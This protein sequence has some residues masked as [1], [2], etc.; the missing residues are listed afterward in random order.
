MVT[1]SHTILSLMLMMRTSL[2]TNT[3][4]GI[5]YLSS[6]SLG[7]EVK[8]NMSGKSSD[9]EDDESLMTSISSDGWLASYST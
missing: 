3:V 6:F 8:G 1:L 2:N 4:S 9:S 7:V 5:S